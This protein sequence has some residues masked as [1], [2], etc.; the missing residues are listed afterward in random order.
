LGI[1]KT[2]LKVLSIDGL[3]EL[4]SKLVSES[5]N[6]QNFLSMG[7]AFSGFILFSIIFTV[8]HWKVVSARFKKTTKPKLSTLDS[9]YEMKSQKLVISVCEINS[10]H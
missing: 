8:I 2:A 3:G 10:L 7:N 6:R 1:S 9:N 4:V 5:L